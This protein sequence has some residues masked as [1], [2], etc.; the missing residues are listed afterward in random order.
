MVEEINTGIIKLLNRKINDIDIQITKNYEQIVF[1]MENGD[2]YKLQNKDDQ[3]SKIHIIGSLHNLA[4]STIRKIKR[5][6]N[7]YLFVTDEGEVK[8]DFELELLDS[9]E[10]V[11]EFETMY[12]K[13]H[14]P[15]L[16]T[17]K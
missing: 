17:K 14:D 16:S 13:S 11:L 2:I 10:D 8:L 1:F 9:L 12:I 4:E 6:D 15:Y 5:V 3:H 7:Y